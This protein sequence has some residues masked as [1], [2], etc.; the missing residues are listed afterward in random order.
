MNEE[1]MKT[2]PQEAIDQTIRNHPLGIGEP[3]DVANLV[4]FLMSEESKWITGTTLIIDG[5]FSIRS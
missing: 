2:L 3:E 4:V 5:G 1:V